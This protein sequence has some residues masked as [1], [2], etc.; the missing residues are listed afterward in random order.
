MT[1]E[2]MLKEMFLLELGQADFKAIGRSRGF[3]PQTMASPQLMQHIFLSEQGVAAVLASLSEMEFLGLH[4]LNCVRE[5]VG[6]EFFRKM[7][8]DSTPRNPFYGTY[9]EQYKALFQQVKT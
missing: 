4:L 7:Y 9:T 3:D 1:K 8:P 5:E 6:L 2:S